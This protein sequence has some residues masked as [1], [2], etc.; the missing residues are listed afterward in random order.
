MHLDKTRV[1]QAEG[2]LN[3]LLE[4][5]IQITT[6]GKLS[7]TQDLKPT[8]LLRLVQLARLSAENLLLLGLGLPASFTEIPN[9][10]VD[11]ED[12]I[13]LDP[14]VLDSNS[15]LKLKIGLTFNVKAE[16]EK[17]KEIANL[18]QNRKREKEAQISE[19]VG[20][21]DDHLGRC[22]AILHLKDSQLKLIRMQYSDLFVQLKSVDKAISQ[23]FVKPLSE[24]YSQSLSPI[25]DDLLQ[26]FEN[27]SDQDS[28]QV[29]V[30]SI[31]N[32]HKDKLEADMHQ[33]G[34]LLEMQK[35]LTKPKTSNRGVPKVS[36]R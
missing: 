25:I 2:K 30:Y 5:L 29:Q 11:Q 21:L 10:I 28:A 19:L 24:L 7:S 23:D 31:L 4:E 22:H 9:R 36:L 1:F 35:K 32:L 20:S 14:I 17:L 26:I 27:C 8:Q 34:H 15:L 18:P 12:V 33:L 6:S 3:E 13:D 16:A